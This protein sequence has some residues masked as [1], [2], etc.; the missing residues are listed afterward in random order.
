MNGWYDRLKY[1]WINRHVLADSEK[2]QEHSASFSAVLEVEATPPNLFILWLAR[3]MVFLPVLLLIWSLTS[4]VNIVASAQ[5]KI[6]S[7]SQVKVIQP[8]QKSVIRRIFVAE[9]E[10]VSKGQALIELDSARASVNKKRLNNELINT[11]INLAVN[12]VLLKRL[13]HKEKKSDQIEAGSLDK[14]RLSAEAESHKTKYNTLSQEKWLQYQ[15][16]I[17]VLINALEVSNDEYEATKTEIG[18]LKKILSIITKS[19]YIAKALH[20]EKNPPEMEILQF[21]QTRLDQSQQLAVVKQQLIQ[22]QAMRDEAQR[23]INMLKTET[24]AGVLAEITENR[25]EIKG[26]EEKL[27]KANEQ[28]M[29]RILYAPVS[30]QVEELAVNAVGGVVIEDEPLMRIV[31]D[32]SSLVVEVFLENKDI[33]FVDKAMPAEVKID[34][35]APTQHGVIQAEVETISG[36]AIFDE[37]RGFVYSMMLAMNR[38]TVEVDG[39]EVRLMP[40]MEVTAEVKVGERR[41]IEYF[42]APLIKHDKE[43]LRQR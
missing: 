40:G 42:L 12:E 43:S 9:G 37:K 2:N 7:D 20:E 30:G 15:S 35:F 41:L 28:N 6:L 24:R 13:N 16:R 1:A 3:S 8:F 22:L 26:L 27:D 23:Q 18:K 34:T 10:N 33:G 36:D 25:L 17:A 4:E 31:P 11:R 32:A 21:E 5:G 29:R 39:K 38:K 14:V 19:A